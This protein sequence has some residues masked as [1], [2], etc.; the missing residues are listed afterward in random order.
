MDEK[1]NF[2]EIRKHEGKLLDFREIFDNEN[3]VHLEIG[4]GRGEF[5]SMKSLL[6]R[7]KNFLGIELKT[8][9]IED[10][11]KKLDLQRHRNVRL[12]R[13]FVDEKITE[14]IPA[15]SVEH[16]YINHPDPWPKKKHNRRRL[17]QNGFIDALKEILKTKG[18]IEINTDHEDYARWI[19][20]I[21]RR[22]D[23]FKIVYE[24][25]FTKIPSEGHIVTHFEEKKRKEGFDPF[26]M[27]FRKI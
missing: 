20:D 10:T 1:W 2:F 4:S 24:N 25:G 22:R 5:I 12:M 11:L 9:R 23:D 15:S 3:P 13:L 18:I 27:K 14:I 16:I 21:F 19:L 6:L 8:K 17:I 7:D 26:F